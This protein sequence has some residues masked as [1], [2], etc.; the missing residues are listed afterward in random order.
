MNEEKTSDPGAR[1][2]TPAQKTNAPTPPQHANNVI[3]VGK[4]EVVNKETGK[5]E[6]VSAEE[7]PRKIN[8]GDTAIKLPESDEQKKG[9]YTKHA[10]VLVSLFP[11][12]YKLVVPKG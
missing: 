12:D 4:R 10:N 7:A 6:K 8:D 11:E 1:T 9:F 5:L 3:F 2:Q